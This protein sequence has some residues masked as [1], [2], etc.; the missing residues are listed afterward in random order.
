MTGSPISSAAAQKRSYSPSL[1][2]RVET[3]DREHLD[4]LREA[5]ERRGFAV[6]VEPVG[7]VE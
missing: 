1:Y 2:G 3:R 6:S 7:V 4:E 5:L